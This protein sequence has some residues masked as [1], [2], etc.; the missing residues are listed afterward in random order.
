LDFDIK[1]TRHSK[2]KKKNQKSATVIKIIYYNVN[3]VV[4]PGN[5]NYGFFVPV[6]L[7]TNEVKKKKLINIGRSE[8]KKIKIIQT[9][10][11]IIL[12]VESQQRPLNDKLCVD[13]NV[14]LI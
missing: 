3:I 9:S 1:N 14:F 11:K 6:N 4:F 8:K 5:D 10:I 7:L 2:K 13:F 12:K